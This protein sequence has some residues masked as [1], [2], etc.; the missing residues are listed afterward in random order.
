VTGGTIQYAHNEKKKKL[1]L[2]GMEV[3]GEFLQHSDPKVL[4]VLSVLKRFL[5]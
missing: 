4:P 3:S 1:S 2:G 5:Q